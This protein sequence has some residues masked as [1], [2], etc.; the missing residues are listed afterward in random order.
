MLKFMDLDTDRPSFRTC[1][2]A[3]IQAY[4]PQG[5]DRSEL[6]RSSRSRLLT[7]SQKM[8]DKATETNDT[9]IIARIIAKNGDSVERRQEFVSGFLKYPGVVPEWEGTGSG[10]PNFRALDQPLKNA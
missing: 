9:A 6:D 7:S 8:F 3:A 4:R 2:A 5:T 10:G 1:S